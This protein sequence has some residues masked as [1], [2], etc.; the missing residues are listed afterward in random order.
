LLTC[1]AATARAAETLFGAPASGVACRLLVDTDFIGGQAIPASVE[2]KNVSDHDVYLAPDHALNPIYDQH[3]TL[4]LTGPDGKP[5]KQATTARATFMPSAFTAVQPGESRRLEIA[6]LR[7]HF[8]PEDLAGE[9]KYTLVYTLSGPKLPDRAESGRRV[10]ERDGKRETE[11]VYEEATPAQKRFAFAGPAVSNQATFAIVA[12]TEKDLAVH[13]WGVFTVF[14]DVRFANANRK[15]EWGALPEFFYRQFPAQ[16]LRWAPAAWDKPVIYFYAGRAG[17]SV[18]VSVK[19]ADG[20]A[21]VVWWPAAAEPANRASG[22]GENEP[23]PRFDALTWRAWLGDT[24]PPADVVSPRAVWRKTQLSEAL[25]ETWLGAARVPGASLVNVP[26]SIPHGSR[27]WQNR[28]METE[29]FVFYDGLVPAPDYLRCPGAGDGS[30]TL[31]NAAKFDMPHLWVIDRRGDS[32]HV[33]R[34]PLGAGEERRV[35]SRRVQGAAG[36]REV[37]GE[38]RAALVAAGLFGPE[39]DAM[40]KIWHK[41]LFE[42]PGAVAFYLLPRAEYD[43]MLPLTVKPAPAAGPVRVGLAYHPNFEANPAIERRVAELIRQLDDG[44][45]RERE[46]AKKALIETGPIALRALREASEKTDSE[47][48]RRLTAR[49]LETIDPSEWLK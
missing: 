17:M 23:V 25:S 37:A 44:N 41:G 1:A 12:P 14:N 31:R 3:V 18:D 46:A 43:R 21:P 26:G 30:V 22:P 48:V 11:T 19:F 32:V 13:E 16:R 7:A 20:G 4:T 42:S 15:A 47:E 24:V 6:N 8:R 45:Y 9:G 34:G 5:V 33:A 10:V 49:I 40:L 28:A 39:A 27:P 36:M 29:G 2:V 38:V 35:D